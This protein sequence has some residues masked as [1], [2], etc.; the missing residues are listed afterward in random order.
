MNLFKKVEKS[1]IVLEQV[2]TDGYGAA[3]DKGKLSVQFQ[4]IMLDSLAGGE[5]QDGS[6]YQLVAGAEFGHG[7]YIWM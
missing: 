5:L 7:E 6:P 4:A 1:S 2:H 3:D